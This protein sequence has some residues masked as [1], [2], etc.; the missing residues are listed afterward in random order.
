[1]VWRVRQFLWNCTFRN[2]QFIHKTEGAHMLAC[3]L[4]LWYPV[5]CYTRSPYSPNKIDIIWRKTLADTARAQEQLALEVA[6][7]TDAQA[8]LQ[9]IS[10]L[11]QDGMANT[12]SAL[13]HWELK[14]NQA[15]N[16]VAKPRCPCQLSQ[17]VS[18]FKMSL[19]TCISSSSSQVPHNSQTCFRR[20]HQMVIHVASLC[21]FH[22][23]IVTMPAFPPCLKCNHLHLCFNSDS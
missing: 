9:A 10:G 23:W 15:S 7:R 6:K 11:L 19:G 13:K 5:F 8:N 14:K 1:M 18:L 20:Q 21:Q 12:M 17:A 3:V 4:L 16:L 2:K 22:A